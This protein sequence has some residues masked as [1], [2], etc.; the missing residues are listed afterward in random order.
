MKR[1]VILC[2][3]IAACAAAPAFA[4][5]PPS[6]IMSGLD[7][8]RGLALGP[9][10]AL[11]VVEAGRG[12]SGPC[13]VLRGSLVCYGPSGALTR[14]WRGTQERVVLGLPSYISPTLEVTGAHDVSFQG[15]G[16]AFISVGFGGDPA[17]RA[18]FGSVGSL[19]GTLIHATP[20]GTW[21]VV[22]DVS[23]HESATNPAGGPIDSNPYGVLAL[24]GARLVTD[25]GANALLRID[26]AGAISTVAVFPSRPVRNT[27]SVPTAIVEGPDGAFYVSEL[28]G[29]PFAAGAARIYRVEPGS[30]PQVYLQ[31]FKTVIDLDFGPDGSLY[32]LQHATG[33]VFFGGPGEIIRVAPDGSRTT[34]LGGL[35]RPTSLLVG[36]DG[37]LFVTNFGIAIGTGEVLRLD[38]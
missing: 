22:A 21:R 23:A 29:A 12:G 13:F 6:V 10:G 27:D 35:N 5:G 19:F 9:E 30:P 28:T 36:P 33:P 3:A 1:T 31:G 2:L 34:V 18:G 32:V 15:R 20:G 4:A 38:P 25:A 7:N 8:P 17:L 37:A 14:L 16:G 26:A 11:Y 24:P